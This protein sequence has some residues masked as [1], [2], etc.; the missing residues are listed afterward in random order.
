MKWGDEETIG[1]G[2]PYL[3]GSRIIER[4]LMVCAKE[5]L[6]GGSESRHSIVPDIL[7]DIRV[8]VEIP[9]IVVILP[10]EYAGIVRE[11]KQSRK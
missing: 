10:V 6:R 3:P 11:G 4:L 8:K 7:L 5:E 2:G 9:T 1:R